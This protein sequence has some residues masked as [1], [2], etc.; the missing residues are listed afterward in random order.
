MFKIF[1]FH[2]PS[3]ANSNDI[4]TKLSPSTLTTTTTTTTT[5]TAAIVFKTLTEALNVTLAANT[6]AI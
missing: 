4:T 6:T 3:E 2:V 1:F 5:K